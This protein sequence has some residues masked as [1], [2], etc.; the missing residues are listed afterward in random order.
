VIVL[1][2]V[3]ALTTTKEPLFMSTRVSSATELRN[4]ACPPEGTEWEVGA[5]TKGS[6]PRYHSV[7]PSC[8]FLCYC[9]VKDRNWLFFGIL[10]LGK[11]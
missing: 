10:E 1:V 3:R 9:Q 2:L 11:R 4:T 8:S 7:S 5:A 6:S